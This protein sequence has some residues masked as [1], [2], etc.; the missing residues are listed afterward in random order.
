MI[1]WI[2]AFI[3]SPITL[4]LFSV[5]SPYAEDAILLFFFLSLFFL[6]Y[7]LL[8]TCFFFPSHPILLGLA[9]G[10]LGV[11]IRMA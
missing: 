9:Y 10:V 5:Y 1:G 3:I 7:S 8:S 2:L 4:D 6:F 11:T